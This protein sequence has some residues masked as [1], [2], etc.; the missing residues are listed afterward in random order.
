MSGNLTATLTPRYKRSAWATWACI[1]AIVI[2]LA[3]LAISFALSP[4]DTWLWLDIFFLIFMGAASGM[5]AWAAAFRVAQARWTPAI[6]R[7]GHSAVAYVPVSALVLIVLL[8]GTSRWIPWVGHPVRGKEAWLNIP[9][10]VIRDVV[11]LALLWG[12]YY[13]MV[14]WSLAGDA[15][16]RR[17]GEISETDHSRLNAVAVAA[18]LAYAFIS[19][20]VSYD[21]IMSLEPEWVSSMFGP[22][23]FC[24]NLYLGMAVIVL[25]AAALR[26]PLGAEDYIK[27]PQ[28]HDMGNLLL[29]FS[30]FNMGL[31]FAQYIT[32]WYENLPEEVRFIILRYDKG[33]WPPVG[34]TSFIVAY[35]IPF[36]LLQSRRLKQHPRMLAPVAVLAVIGV[37][38]ERYVMVA[39]SI[40]PSRLMLFPTGVLTFFAF[41]GA[42][43]LA[44]T[45]FLQRY[46]PIS[47]PQEALRK[48]DT[49]EPL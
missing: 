3:G 7:L 8:A 13:L 2:G 14:R 35:G 36:V 34:W 5:L 41:L 24:T 32:I 25:M 26:K 39:P 6:S 42:F 21:F 15:K 12:L 48:I 23:F 31:F 9:F 46:S 16:V 28:F 1:A 18:T 49:T 10:M 47:A 40:H 33:M 19:T 27:S 4:R 43:L 30:L 29:A 45:S 38:L 44:V 22:Y 37:S 11:G 20:L 17:G